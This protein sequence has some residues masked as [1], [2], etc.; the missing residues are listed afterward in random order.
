MHIGKQ[1]T[2]IYFQP[3]PFVK[4][5]IVCKEDNCGKQFSSAY[6]YNVHIKRHQKKY[7]LICQVCGKGFMNSNHLNSHTNSHNK[8]KPFGCGFCGKR[9]VTNSNLTRH[10]ST[11]QV[12]TKKFQCI[13]CGKLFL[14]QGTLNKHLQFIHKKIV[15]VSLQEKGK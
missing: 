14:T 4:E 15:M 1:I 3:C 7:K 5:R 13:I 2:K 8:N 11:C 6:N 12:I 10:Q 9:F